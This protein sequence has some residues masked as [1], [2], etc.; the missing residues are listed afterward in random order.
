MRPVSVYDTVMQAV[1]ERR[2]S[3]SEALQIIDEFRSIYPDVF[4]QAA[5][6][7]EYPGDFAERLPGRLGFGE[8]MNDTERSVERGIED[9]I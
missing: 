5:L 9:E 1:R 6:A 7:S 3:K 8:H 4:Q 2:F